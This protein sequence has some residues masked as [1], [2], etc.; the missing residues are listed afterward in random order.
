MGTRVFNINFAFEGRDYNALVSVKGEERSELSLRVDH[1]FIH[2]WLPHGKIS[3][4]IAEV[5]NYFSRLKRERTVDPVMQITST[6]SLH[7][8]MPPL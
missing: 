7:L 6:I 4:T 5:V 3:F 2:L 8:L 1:Q